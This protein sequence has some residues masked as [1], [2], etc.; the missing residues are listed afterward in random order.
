MPGPLLQGDCPLPAWVM[1]TLVPHPDTIPE[2]N[3][4][5]IFKGNVGQDKGAATKVEGHLQITCQF[6]LQYSLRR[7]VL[8]SQGQRGREEENADSLRAPPVSA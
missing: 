5:H 2:L 8:A 1:K 3:K 6:V 7:S 4:C